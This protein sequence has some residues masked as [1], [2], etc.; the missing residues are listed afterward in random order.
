M[1]P[2]NHQLVYVSR[3][4]HCQDRDRSRVGCW[5]GW[6]REIARN[7]LAQGRIWVLAV[8]FCALVNPF[9]YCLNVGAGKSSAIVRHPS[10]RTFRGDELIKLAFFKVARRDWHRSKVARLHHQFESVDAIMALSRLRTVA[11]LASADN[12]RSHFSHEADRLGMA[13]VSHRRAAKYPQNVENDQIYCVCDSSHSVFLVGPTGETII[14]ADSP[15][16]RR[17]SEC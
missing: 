9:P 13:L 7:L 6:V 16:L 11:R 4:G 3:K 12:D 15:R 10:M 17:V 14:I 1:V 5:R 2:S 8:E